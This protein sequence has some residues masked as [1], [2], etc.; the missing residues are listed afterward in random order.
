MLPI[1]AVELLACAG[2]LDAMIFV[3]TWNGNPDRNQISS[4]CKLMC[5]D[6]PMLVCLNKA[7]M[8]EAEHIDSRKASS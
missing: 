8:F 6:V 1:S 3:T 2:H 7:G 4:I 5:H